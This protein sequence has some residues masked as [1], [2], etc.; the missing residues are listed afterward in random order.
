MSCSALNKVGAICGLPLSH[1]RWCDYH[2]KRMIKYYKTYKSLET[3]IPPLDKIDNYDKDQL[4]K[5]NQRLIKIYHYRT[6][7][8]QQG[9]PD[10]QDEGHQSRIE[11]ILK[12]IEIVTAKV[13]S[14]TSDSNSHQ[15]Y[16]VFKARI[17]QATSSKKSKP[18][19]EQRR[20]GAKILSND[21]RLFKLQ[22]EINELCDTIATTHLSSLL[23]LLTHYFVSKF[24]VIRGIKTMTVSLDCAIGIFMVLHVHEW[25]LKM[26]GGCKKVEI[27]GAINNADKVGKSYKC[28]YGS[29]LDM[30]IGIRET[31]NTEC[32]II[33]DNKYTL[34]FYAIYIVAKSYKIDLKAL[35]NQ[36]HDSVFTSDF[37]CD[38]NPEDPV[39]FRQ[40]TLNLYRNLMQTSHDRELIES[41]QKTIDEISQY[42]Y[43]FPL[44]DIG[45]CM[46]VAWSNRILDWK[47]ICVG[48]NE[49]IL[50][51][52]L[53]ESN[54]RLKLSNVKTLKEFYHVCTFSGKILH[55]FYVEITG[56]KKCNET[57]AYVAFIRLLLEGYNISMIAKKDDGSPFSFGIYKPNSK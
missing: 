28:R 17:A 37:N 53:L 10:Y 21:E 33:F 35:A 7:L 30:L 34:F 22:P 23:I 52:H 20:S 6:T 56:T 13:N 29:Y 42:Y 16:E 40:T 51:S 15:D 54:G 55:D 12:M 39:F 44:L 46:R 45:F 24:G 38:D 9:Y 1:N 19:K 31:K 43:D 5:L 50:N 48:N 49:F 32:T 4:I 26:P 36:Y 11:N 41:R 25:D 8:R 3:T 47:M 14:F 2:A 27:D 18:K 57:L